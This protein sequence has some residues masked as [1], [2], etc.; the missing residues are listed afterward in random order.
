VRAHRHRVVRASSQA[1]VKVGFY[2]PLPPARTGVADYSAALLKRLRAFGQVEPNA[3]RSDI[4]LYH[5]GNNQ[6]HR[7]IY[8]RALAEPG[9]AV[10]HDAVLQ[11][12]FLGSLDQAGYVEEFCYN[13]GAWNRDLAERLWRNRARSATDPMYFRY[14]MLKRIALA[15]RAIVVHNPAAAEMV[16]AHAPSAVIHEI[17]HLFEAPPPIRISDVE[18]L[19]ARLGMN[20]GAFVFGVFG[21]LR[22][23]KRLMTILR[24]FA[25]A[26]RRAPML[27]LIAGEFASSDLARAAGPLLAAEGVLRAGYLTEQD[28]WMH[29]S[30]VD[31]C[32]NLRYPPAGETSGIAIRLMGLG[33]PVLLTEGAE[34]SR[35]PESA[36]ARVAGGVAEQDMLIELMLWLAAC[37]DDAREMGRRARAYII[38]AHDPQRAAQHY[39]NLLE[40]E[41]PR[42]AGMI[43]TRGSA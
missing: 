20:T 5:L 38:E 30:A 36:C 18:R 33:K 11:H 3:A 21:H 10:L 8:Q 1:Y 25:A 6:L 23:S 13:Y 24:A 43:D 9:V 35:F 40:L 31:A 27:L 41:A 39:W 7:A 14:P 17:P 42:A 2:S 26:R 29:A 28:F 19:R 22:E 37:P 12:F 34:T 32:I 16:R 4:A 15:S